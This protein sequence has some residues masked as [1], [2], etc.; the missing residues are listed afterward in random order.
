MKQKQVLFTLILTLF[1]FSLFNCISCYETKGIFTEVAEPLCG[2]SENDPPFSEKGS[3]TDD[4]ALEHYSILEDKHSNSIILAAVGDIMVHSPQLSSAYIE[5]EGTY[6][7]KDCFS[8]IAPYLQRADFVTGNLETTFGGTESGYSGYPFFNSPPELADALRE[9]GFGLLF[10]ANN[11][12]MDSGEQGVLNTISVIEEKSLGFAGTSR[13]REEREKG[14]IL[15]QNNIKVIFYAYTYGTN[16]IPLPAGKEYLVPLIDEQLIAEDINR[17]KNE[18]QADIV[19]VGLHWG[20]EYQRLPSPYQQELA[21]KLVEMGADI[22]VGTHPHVI[23]PAEIIKT[24]KGEGLV[25]YSLGNFISNQRWRYSDAG[26]IVYLQI[27]LDNVLQRSNVTILEIVPTW[28]HKYFQ[29]G[30]WKY[31]V[32]PVRE[33]IETENAREIYKLSNQDYQ[34]LKEVLEETEEIFWRFWPN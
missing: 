2:I 15:Y 21:R 9:S 10:T 18:L 24:E 11:H 17:A 34:R 7:F 25:L 23:Q 8:P 12:S 33:V 1:C 32:L 29:G 20:E 19:V 27:E 5:S 22:I 3:F 16:G 4:T 26:I 13:H 28:V 14:F 6:N 30:K 31:T